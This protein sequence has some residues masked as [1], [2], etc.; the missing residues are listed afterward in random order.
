MTFDRGEEGESDDDED[1]NFR[2][3]GRGKTRDEEIVGF[4]EGG[5]E[6]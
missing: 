3:K 6:R 4:G 5:A 1:G 2:G